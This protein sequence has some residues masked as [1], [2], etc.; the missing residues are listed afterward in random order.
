M[1]ENPF[2][3]GDEP[4][5][6]Q[7]RLLAVFAHP[8]DEAFGAGGTLARY[9]AEG[10]HVTLL[11]V[12]RGEAGMSSNLPLAGPAEVGAQRARELQCSCEALGIHRVCLLSYP[13]GQLSEQT[14]EE[15]IERIARAI[16]E[17]RPHVII[18]F[19]PD[20]V[21]GHPDHVAISH[22]TTAA[23]HRAGEAHR[24]EGL[25]TH[26]PERLF[27]VAIPASIARQW[28]F[29]DLHATPD[30]RIGAVIDISD[31]TPAKLKALRCHRS[32]QS[33]VDRVLAAWGGE[34]TPQE[35]F[36]LAAPAIDL[37]TPDTDLF[38]G[39]AVGLPYRGD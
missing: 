37:A 33:D 25:L 22:L 9:A 31:Y 21:T 12:T 35:F 11:T 24:T 17:L 34:L 4:G 18:T 26:R 30:E 27:Y 5:Q 1:A 14:P 2:A 19:G 23:F 20:G 28:E 6:E 10:A 3:G 15:V 16:R 8:D 38:Q 7:A 13:D 32:Q 39:L 36:Q 29:D